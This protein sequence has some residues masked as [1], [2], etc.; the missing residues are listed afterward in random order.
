MKKEYKVGVS[1]KSSKHMMPDGKMMTKKKVKV[2]KK[3]KK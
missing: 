3:K 2:V 1:V